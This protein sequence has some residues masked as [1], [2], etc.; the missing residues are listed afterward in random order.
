MAL[1][2]SAISK[3][4][5]WLAREAVC[6]PQVAVRYCPCTRL[7]TQCSACV[8]VCVCICGC[9]YCV[10]VFFLCTPHGDVRIDVSGLTTGAE[11]S[12]EIR[13]QK[14]LTASEYASSV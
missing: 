3:V 7:Y 9:V 10:C 4:G 14:I 2:S 12:A 11:R 6:P 8:C 13:A 5:K 1:E